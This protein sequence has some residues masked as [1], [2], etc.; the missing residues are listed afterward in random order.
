MD[1]ETQAIECECCRSR[2]ATI[3]DYRF[4]DKLN[5]AGKVLVCDYCANLSDV[6]FYIEYTKEK[7]N[8]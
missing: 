8:K 7:S 5:I 3:K 2:P 1:K 6:D 4:I